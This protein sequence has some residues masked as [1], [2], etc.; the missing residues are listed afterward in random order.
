MLTMYALI[1]IPKTKNQVE[2]KSR[3]TKKKI[4]K[5]TNKRNLSWASISNKITN[6]FELLQ[7]HN[8][9]QWSRTTIA[10]II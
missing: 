2:M 9:S 6:W 1:Y 7:N 5:T 10:I 8:H 4:E 3:E